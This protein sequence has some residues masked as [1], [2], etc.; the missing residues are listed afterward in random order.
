V[1]IVRFPPAGEEHD[2]H[3]VIDAIDQG[4][5]AA[6]H[7]ISMAA[8]PATAARCTDQAGRY[9]LELNLDKGR[10]MQAKKTCEN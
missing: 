4:L 5:V 1:P 7:D 6:C 8:W 10:K 3:A 2:L 9:G